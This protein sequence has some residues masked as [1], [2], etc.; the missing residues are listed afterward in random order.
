VDGN[1]TIGTRN[2]HPHPSLLYIPF[3]Y[4]IALWV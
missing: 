4:L 1:S 2:P 3:F